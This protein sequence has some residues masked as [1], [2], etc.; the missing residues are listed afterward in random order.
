MPD[1]SA[2]DLVL[3]FPSNDPQCRRHTITMKLS[4]DTSP[5]D[6]D[7]LTTDLTEVLGSLKDVK[8]EP[9]D[10]PLCIVTGFDEVGICVEMRY[11]FP[12]SLPALDFMKIKSQVLIRM[13]RRLRSR[14]VQLASS[15]RMQVLSPEEKQ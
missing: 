9:G 3:F 6:L 13:L 1:P 4:L 11:R 12:A 2:D 15:Q 5:D 7:L 10:D 14:G 8:L